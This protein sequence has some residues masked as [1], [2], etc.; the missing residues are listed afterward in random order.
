MFSGIAEEPLMIPF[1]E[2]SASEVFSHYRV[3]AGSKNCIDKVLS[4]THCGRS[5]IPY[6][7]ICLGAFLD[8]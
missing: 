3:S 6:P 5:A 1:R 7:L 4:E 8:Q 2:V